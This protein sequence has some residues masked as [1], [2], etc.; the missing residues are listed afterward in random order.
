[1]VCLCI[2]WAPAVFVPDRDPETILPALVH[3]SFRV[4]GP[5]KYIVSDQEGALYSDQ[6]VIWA[7]RWQG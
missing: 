6:G 3:M 1:M 4:Y 2:K 5:P 7:D